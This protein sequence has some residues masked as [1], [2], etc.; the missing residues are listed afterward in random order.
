MKKLYLIPARGGSKGVPGKNIKE[1][2]GKPLIYYS[3]DAARQVADDKDICVSTDSEQIIQKVSEYGLDVPFIRPANLA[4]D[5]AGTNEVILH[6]LE[7][8]EKRGVH[9]DQ[10]V[11]LQPTSPFRKIEDLRSCLQLFT[12]EIDM[13]VSVKESKANPYYNLFEEDSDGYLHRSK[14]SSFSRRQDS[15]SIFEYNGSIYV[16]NVRSL[17]NKKIN[18]FTKVRKFVMDEIYSLDI[19]TQLDWEMVEFISNKY[20]LV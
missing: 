7:F 1:L 19:D 12:N 9:Y 15:P 20:L 4:T 6:A 8:Y 11:I 2:K 5:T 17:K 16:I 14:A 13:V 10:I 18:E 3:I